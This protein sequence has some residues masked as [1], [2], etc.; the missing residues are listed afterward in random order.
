VKD[1][2]GLKITGEPK[3]DL[4]REELLKAVEP[5]EIEKIEAAE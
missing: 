3:L 2:F 5:V 4:I 1:I